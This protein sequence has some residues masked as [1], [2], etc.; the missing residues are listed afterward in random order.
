M[1]VCKNNSSCY[2][3]PLVRT[4]EN[5]AGWMSDMVTL[6][7]STASLSNSNSM[8]YNSMRYN[9]IVSNI[10]N[11]KMVRVMVF[12]ATANLGKNRW[13]KKPIRWTQNH[14]RKLV[15]K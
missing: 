10:Y 8:R 11:I 4:M 3:L 13:G 15:G 7:S 12:S 6:F 1:R 9:I 2:Y 14:S 5:L